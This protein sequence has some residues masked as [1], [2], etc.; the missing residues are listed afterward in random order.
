M[1]VRYANALIQCQGTLRF[2]LWKQLLFGMRIC[3]LG[4]HTLPV[5]STGTLPVASTGTL[6]MASTGTGIPALE[7]NVA[8][9]VH[10]I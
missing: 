1:H 4:N 8:S 7:V 2:L 10:S 6:P 3:A 5:A 9:H